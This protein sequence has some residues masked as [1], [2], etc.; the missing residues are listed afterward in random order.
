MRKIAT[1]LLILLVIAPYF[2]AFANSDVQAVKATGQNP[3]TTVSEKR[4]LGRE[5]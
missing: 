4:T 5:N 3:V 2:M 1:L